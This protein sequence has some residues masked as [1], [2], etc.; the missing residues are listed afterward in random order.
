FS[1]SALAIHILGFFQ[2]IRIHAD[3]GVQFVVVHRYAMEVL[4]YQLSRCDASLFHRLLHFR[5]GRLDD[6]EWFSLRARNK[7]GRR[8]EYA[9]NQQSFHTSFFFF[10]W[11]AT[12]WA[13]RSIAAGSPR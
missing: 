12:A 7:N 6:A 11:S 4:L 10:V 13:A 5:D 3:C 8:A 2:G 9:N 1:A